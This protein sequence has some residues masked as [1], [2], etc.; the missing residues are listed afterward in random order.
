MAC[1]SA[2]SLLLLQVDI[3]AASILKSLGALLMTTLT[4][5]QHHIPAIPPL[6]SFSC[7]IFSWLGR[8]TIIGAEKPHLLSWAFQYL[9]KPPIGGSLP[10]LESKQ[11]PSALRMVLFWSQKTSK[12][13]QCS[14]RHYSLKH[15]SLISVAATFLIEKIKSICLNAVSLV[16]L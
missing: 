7:G 1:Y 8:K 3:H 15:N 12:L 14:L 4:W 2:I 9:W 6:P 11:K 5:S 13:L 10:N 16:L